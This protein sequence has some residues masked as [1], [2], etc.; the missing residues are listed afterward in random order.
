MEV[1]YKNLYIYYLKGHADTKNL[2]FNVDFLGNWEEGGYSFLFFSTPSKDKL[3]YILDVQ[4]DLTFI[5]EY[6]FSYE[7]WHGCKISSQNI[8]KFFIVPPWDNIKNS[9]EKISIILDPGVVFGNGTHPTTSD[10]IYAIEEVF[11][12]D[13]INS[14]MDIGTG[15]G[16]LSLAIAKL[17]S[18][19][20]IAVDFNF[21]AA[22]TAMKNVQLNNLKDKIIVICGR[23][24]DYV[25][26]PC[27]LL[28]A[29]IHY[30]IMKELIKSKG[31]WSKKWLILSGLFR[32]QAKDI[33]NQLLAKK[34]Q[35]VRTW[36]TSS[37][38]NTFLIK[39][40]FT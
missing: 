20:T 22:K 13:K 10:C 17:S 23:G 9:D 8:G 35:I 29:N 31:F 19:K 26:I 25:D 38:W 2:A 14:A 3:A 1:P 37:I 21:L 15:T 36:E 18:K 39:N 30:D 6:K 40:T 12:L 5:D 28:V 24:E 32:S 33:E 16:I 27:D 4:N 11:F 7:E 34:A